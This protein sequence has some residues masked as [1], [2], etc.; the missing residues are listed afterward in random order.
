M[1]PVSSTARSLTEITFRIDQLSVFELSGNG[2]YDT[3]WWFDAKTYRAS[4][5]SSDGSQLF[6]VQERPTESYYFSLAPPITGIMEPGTYTL[7]ADLIFN[8]GAFPLG[9]GH[10]GNISLLLRVTNVPDFG[11]TVLPLGLALLGLVAIRRK[12]S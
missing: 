5:T 6:Q 1:G 3:E 10:S 11:S 12:L 4:L 8:A 7:S 2:S 9:E